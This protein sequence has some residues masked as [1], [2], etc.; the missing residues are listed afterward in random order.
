MK[1]IK[2]LDIDRTNVKTLRQQIREQI[3]WLIADGVL[4]IGDKLPS[5]H[6]LSEQLGVN[7]H[8]IRQ[9]YHQLEDDGLVESRQGRGTHIIPFNLSNLVNAAGDTRSH[10]VGVVVPTWSNP[11]YHNFLQGVESVA[12]GNK[13]M[14]F[15]C[16]TQD[17]PLTA[18]R[19]V[20][21]LVTKG[22][23]G[24]LIVSHDID[25][26]LDK[27]K[28]PE[29]IAG[30]PYV[31]VD[32][33]EANGFAVN[34]DLYS[35]GYQATQHLAALGHQ[36]IALMTHLKDFHNVKPINQGYEGA[37]KDADIKIDK[38]LIC[39][40]P[41]FQF[42]A[43]EQ[44]MRN[45]L[46]SD[47]LPTAIFAITDLMALGAMKVIKEAG[48]RIPDD[49]SIVG[50]NDIPMVEVV[51]PPLTTVF[52]PSEAL[53][54]ESMKM[55]GQLIEG[56]IPSGRKILLPTTLVVRKSARKLGV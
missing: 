33:P 45:L 41:G 47:A 50:F 51:D 14:I 9:A 39:K 31:S 48:L 34:I 52:A 11:F 35:A 29:C 13:T 43:G 53:G 15:L 25:A 37:L 46:K 40:V 30:I 22:V 56:S 21:R 36:R 23:D 49:I 8:T 16:M 44:G 3:T 7:L 26:I 12:A 17:D 24:L 19:E 2:Y 54:R 55:L 1:L 38:S 32:S 42:A 5:I 18:W 6:E 27:E 20:A 28:D 10:T 4:K